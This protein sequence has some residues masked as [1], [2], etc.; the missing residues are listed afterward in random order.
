MDRQGL[1]GERGEPGVRGGGTGGTGGRGGSGG[2]SPAWPVVVV[3]C[4]LW[5]GA[6]TYLTATQSTTEKVNTAARAADARQ[7]R[8]DFF[9]CQRRSTIIA[10]QVVDRGIN[11]AQPVERQA[12]VMRLYG[13]IADCDRTVNVG[14]IVLLPPAARDAY[15]QGIANRLGFSDWNVQPDGKWAE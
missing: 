13:G 1:P 12:G 15:V 2:V 3:A 14:R 6:L 4:L 11:A 10:A 9:A 5:M 7:D 8:S